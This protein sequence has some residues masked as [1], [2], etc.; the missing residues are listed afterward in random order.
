[1]SFVIRGIK[2]LFKKDNQD[3]GKPSSSQKLT[4]DSG[5]PSS[6][7][8]LTISANDFDILGY[9]KQNMDDRLFFVI[10]EMSMICIEDIKIGDIYIF[11]SDH[12][13][14]PLCVKEHDEE[15]ESIIFQTCN[16]SFDE[17]PRFKW[18]TEG[19]PS[20]F[21]E[22]ITNGI[23][24][25]QQSS[26]EIKEA[27]DKIMDM[28]VDASRGV[29]M[30]WKSEEF[31]GKIAIAMVEAK[32]RQESKEGNEIST[33]PNCL[34][35]AEFVHFINYPYVFDS[36]G[37]TSDS[38]NKKSELQEA[39]EPMNEFLEDAYK[40]R[41]H[42]DALKSE[43]SAVAINNT[44]S[45][46]FFDGYY[47][48][49][50]MIAEMPNGCVVKGVEEISGRRYAI[51]KIRISSEQKNN[52]FIRKYYERHILKEIIHPNILRADI[53]SFGKVV[54]KLYSHKGANIEEF[55]KENSYVQRMLDIN[56]KNRPSAH[57]CLK[58]FTQ[59]IPP[60]QELLKDE[61][62]DSVRA[63]TSHKLTIDERLLE[64][65]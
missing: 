3:S 24:F 20:P 42:I 50:E 37:K 14:I 29:E 21:L 30:D 45:R 56:P 27:N 49:V 33:C 39:I 43:L 5:E 2:K 13:F 51:K 53:Y 23:A 9:V 26:K 36:Q 28:L 31:R 10:D 59:L 1:M 54:E 34:K 63:N 4:Q 44:P 8:K 55:E 6:S 61:E 12:N 60:I 11:P 41:M 46:S 58:C 65:D 15:T 7:Q 64:L 62:V 47:S 48:N 57:D 35:R 25:V 18:K 40:L 22:I 19:M 52:W 32:N 38:S 17:L 16:N